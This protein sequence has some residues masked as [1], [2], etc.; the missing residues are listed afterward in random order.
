MDAEDTV[1]GA[2]APTRR[3]HPAPHEGADGPRRRVS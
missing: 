2:F 3:V 1:R